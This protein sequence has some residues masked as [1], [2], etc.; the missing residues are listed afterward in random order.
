MVSFPSERLGRQLEQNCSLK[1]S[2]TARGEED[3][4]ARGGRGC[5]GGC[6]E[7]WMKP[8]IL[9]AGGVQIYIQQGQIETEEKLVP[10]SL[11]LA[12]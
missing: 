11:N 2:F 9:A 3:L 5:G 7:I 6:V 1:F 10:T 4:G 8:G 12:Q